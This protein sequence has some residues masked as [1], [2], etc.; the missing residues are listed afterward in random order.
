M[1]VDVAREEVGSTGIVARRKKMIALNDHFRKDR[2]EGIVMLSLSVHSMGRS[3][4]DTILR[5]IAG[6]EGDKSC[7]DSEEHEYGEFQHGEHT[8]HWDIECYNKALD[9]DSPDSTNPKLTTR[10][11]SILLGTDY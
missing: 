1:S 4:V 3:A 9:D 6:S 10:Y 2:Q 11:M 7:T 5:K 8:I